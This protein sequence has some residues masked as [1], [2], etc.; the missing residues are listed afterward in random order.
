MLLYAIVFS[1]FCERTDFE[2]SVR[3]KVEFTGR[4]RT[5]GKDIY[6]FVLCIISFKLLFWTPPEQFTRVGHGAFQAESLYPSLAVLV[7]Q[8]ISAPE[9][10]RLVFHL[11]GPWV[12]AV[13]TPQCWMLLRQAGIKSGYA[14][15]PSSMPKS[16]MKM[17]R[18]LGKWSNTCPTWSWRWMRRVFRHCHCSVNQQPAHVSASPNHL[19]TVP[20][21][22]CVMVRVKWERW[23]ARH[24][25]PEV[26]SPCDGSSCPVKLVWLKGHWAHTSLLWLYLTQP[27]PQARD[28]EEIVAPVAVPFCPR[29]RTPK[30]MGS[31]VRDYQV[32]GVQ[33]YVCWPL[34]LPRLWQ[35]PVLAH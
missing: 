11:P 26:Y 14:V 5:Y 22:R 21:F 2:C 32:R 9:S 4:S 24:T 28:T 6:V 33:Y 29:R 17:P 25:V 19:Q 7:G 10:C 13:Q 34:G 27:A 20:M 18:W 23:A 30:V 12:R 3:W 1:G 31:M 16:C 15:V 35:H 8:P